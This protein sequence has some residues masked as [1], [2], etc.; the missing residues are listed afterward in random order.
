ML[1]LGID[2]AGRGPV[3]G[4]M[5]I[6]GVLVDDKGMRSLVKLGVK[7][8]KVLTREQRDKLAKEIEIIAREIRLVEVTAR[9]IDEMRK[10]MSLNEVEARKIVELIEKFEN[11]P[12]KIIIDCPDP[13]PDMFVNRLKAL[14]DTDKYQLVV[15]HKAD[16]NYPV[17]SAA[18]IIAKVARDMHMDKLA[19]QHGVKMGTGYPHDPDAIKAIEHFLEKDGRLPPFVRKSWDTAK[20]IV[21]KKTQKKLVDF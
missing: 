15:E 14:I 11:K 6:A 2:E 21:D 10:V 4:S 13:I 9:D 5:M 7:D 17:V 12:D 18:S 8:S 20:R 1:T 3:I 16:A 19:K